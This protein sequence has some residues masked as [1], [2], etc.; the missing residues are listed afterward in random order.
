[1]DFYSY[2]MPPKRKTPCVIVGGEWPAT[3]VK[4]LV[5]YQT[6]HFEW[7]AARIETVAL[8]ALFYECKDI[9]AADA[10]PYCLLHYAT[11]CVW[12]FSRSRSASIPVPYTRTTTRTTI[13]HTAESRRVKCHVGI[14]FV[15]GGGA[16]FPFGG[17]YQILTIDR[18]LRQVICAKPAVDLQEAERLLGGFRLEP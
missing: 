4:E 1:M 8:F 13:T 9:A 6:K 18:V 16:A 11:P 15:G 5:Y 10:A 17:Q 12:K 2:W 14:M 3:A 7:I